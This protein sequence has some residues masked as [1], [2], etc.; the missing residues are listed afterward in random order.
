MAVAELTDKKGAG[1]LGPDPAPPGQPA[2]PHS[3]EAEQSVLGGLLLDNSAL[4]V[5]SDL[6]QPQSFYHHEHQAVFAAVQ[7]LCKAG[8]PADPVTVFEQLRINGLGDGTD[9]LQYLLQ[10]EQGVTS[11]RNV[12]RYAEIVAGHY[13][14]RALLAAMDEATRVAQD[15]LM[16]MGDRLQRIASAVAKV[17]RLAE[18][19]FGARV[20]ML[21]L[22][23]LRAAHEQ[24][25][26]AVKG[27]LPASSLGMMF[28][29]SG[30]FKSFI[31][32]DAALHVAHGLPWLGRITKAAPV[33]YIAAEGGA[34]LW[35]RINAWHKARG[36]KWGEVPFYVV[37]HAVD[38]TADAWRVVD[39]AQALGV[40]FG[41]VVVDTLS[42]TYS[43]EENSANEM[44]AYFREIGLRFRELWQCTVLLVHHSGHSSTERPRG[45]SAIRANVDFLLG[46]FRDEKELLA[47]LTCVK[48]KDGELFSDANFRMHVQDLGLDEDGDKLTSLVARHLSSP[49]EVEEA[50]LAE[51]AAG[52][53]GRNTA[54][55]QLISNAMSLSDLR[56]QFYDLLEGLDSEAK[57]KAFF[58]AKQW[59][60]DAKFIEV[61]ENRVVDLR[62]GA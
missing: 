32:L 16:P 29:G 46:V 4:A 62:P 50:R 11:A 5:V 2:P 36:L 22:D 8:Q 54:F 53:G 19:G 37:P 56:K 18:G 49:E 14:S 42:Q 44:A 13:A 25:R 3:H 38:L 40:R 45:S 57:K 34:G 12:R 27:V 58:R 24:I 55:M 61:I 1:P 20:P 39:A 60:L 51:Q 17:E 59:A 52:R 6:L 28:G 33:L 10:M 21:R 31:A 7:T 48:Q 47:T 41:L 23:A 9:Q 26:W 35:A 43:G 15:Q 30:T